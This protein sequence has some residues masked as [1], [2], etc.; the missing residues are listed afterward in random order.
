[1]VLAFVLLVLDVK[2]PTHGVLTVGAIISLI[3]GAFIFFNSGSLTGPQVNPLVVYSMAGLV[4]LIGFSLVTVI[5]RVQRRP[6]TTGVEAMIGA[7][8]VALTP[9]LPEGRVSYGG[10]NWAAVLAD[11]AT[12]VDEG[13]EV[14]VVGV[15]GLRLHV[16]PLYTHPTVDTYSVPSLE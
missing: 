8:V 11:P 1:M 6:V 12:S 2:L 9:L 4:G 7:K 10:E 3:F 13:A 14:Q 5:V 15:E 16:Q